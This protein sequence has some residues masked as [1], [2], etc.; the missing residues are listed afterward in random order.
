MTST[1]KVRNAQVTEDKK[2]KQQPVV[3]KFDTFDPVE[4]AGNVDYLSV[5]VASQRRSGKTIVVNDLVYKWSS[6]KFRN[7]KN[8]KRLKMFDEC[9]LFSE[10]AR[11]S[12]Q[13]KF[14][15]K[16]N[17]Y[18]TFDDVGE[19]KINELWERNTK[20]IEHNRNVEKG[21]KKVKVPSVLVIFDDVVH[22]PI[23]RSSGVV[24]KLYVA[25]RHIHFSVITISQN[26]LGQTG[27]PNAVRNNSDLVIVFRNRDFN[28]RKSICEWWLSCD[29][30]ARDMMSTLENATAPPYQAVMIDL[31]KTEGVNKLSDYVST[32]T[33]DPELIKKKW[34][35]GDKY[36]AVQWASKKYIPTINRNTQA[37]AFRGDL[38][39][40][41]DH[42]PVTFDFQGGGFKIKSSLE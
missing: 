28:A 16:D 37:L 2:T 15:P 39:D 1:N 40:R 4:F 35:I 12:D 38:S 17:V 27:L 30:S 34:T 9:Y 22:L 31:A 7:P 23:M 13:Y 14:I 21:E 29:M 5:Y 32:Y 36:D 18:D 41:V 24:K 11:L 19:N 33:A 6:G 42:T 25:G 10:T 8:G 3:S 26:V 20:A